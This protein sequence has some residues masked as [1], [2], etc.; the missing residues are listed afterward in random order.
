MENSAKNIAVFL[1]PVSRETLSPV[2]SSIKSLLRTR[3]SSI[4]SP[5]AVRAFKNALDREKKSLKADG[6]GVPQKSDI[7]MIPWCNCS[8][9]LGRED[10]CQSCGHERS[11][12]ASLREDD[13]ECSSSNDDGIFFMMENG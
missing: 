6:S 7:C 10:S 8:I 9:F 13:Q 1:T 4:T 2:T 5:K 12:H 11:L 3:R